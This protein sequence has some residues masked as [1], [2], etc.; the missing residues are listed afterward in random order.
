MR[1]LIF[2]VE[3]SV[4]S[5]CP[6]CGDPLIYRDTC[7]RILLLEGH[8]HHTYIIRRLKCH[9]CSKLHRELPD[10]LAPYKHYACE[11]ISGVLDG[12]ITPEDEDS[13]DYP[14]EATMVRWRDWFTKNQL[15]V[16]GFLKSIG[17]RLPG[18]SEGLLKTGRSLLE[19]LRSSHHRW[20]EVILRFIYNSGDFLVAI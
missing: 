8:I 7:K 18:F 14:C 2:F 1:N 10:I 6:V 9:H 16:D 15:R 17:S 3:S 13:A 20:L 5:Y 4:T 12:M 11:I 19:S